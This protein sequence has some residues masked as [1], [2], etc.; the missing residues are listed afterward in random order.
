MEVFCAECGEQ[1]AEKL[2]RHC[3]YC[4]ARLP[5]PYGPGRTPR[6]CDRTCRDKAYYRRKHV[7]VFDD[8]GAELLRARDY[9]MCRWAEADEALKA[10]QAELARLQAL[11]APAEV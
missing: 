1:L 4:F 8:P 2:A 10:A 9:W 3:A 6:Y 11:L 5:Q 7:P